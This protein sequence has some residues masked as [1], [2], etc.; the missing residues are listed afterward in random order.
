MSADGAGRK[1][2]IRAYGEGA[3][4]MGIFRVR[5]AARGA[6]LVGPS[7]DLPAMLNRQRAQLRGHA[8][9]NRELQRDW[10]ELGAE[11]F[12]FEVL[13]TLEP[14]D[15]PGY[16]PAEELRALLELWREKLIASGEGLY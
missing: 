9:V 1:A 2:A 10:D 14:R 3:R 16:D 12:A 4:P 15:T 6:S 11:A 8:H 5:N 13:D 7:K